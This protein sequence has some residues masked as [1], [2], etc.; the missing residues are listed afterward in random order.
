MA[1]ESI[2][3]MDL[4]NTSPGSAVEEEQAVHSQDQPLKKS[5]VAPAERVLCLSQQEKIK[6][7]QHNSKLSQRA[8]ID[9]C[10]TK[11]QMKKVICWRYEQF[12]QVRKHSAVQ[13]VG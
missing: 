2:A 4:F 11:F 9:W 8:L 3:E 13:D 7:V 5:R 12:S 10:F 1:G 6:L